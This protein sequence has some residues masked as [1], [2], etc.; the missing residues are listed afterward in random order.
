M[1]GRTARQKTEEWIRRYHMADRGDGVLAA[2]SGGADSVCLLLLLCELRETLGIRV[3]AFHLNHG[4]RGAEADWDE[5]YVRALCEKLG[6][7]LTVR[8]EDVASYAVSRRL[9]EEEA[10]RRLRYQYLEETAD[11][12]GFRRIAT[13]HHRDDCAETVLMNL[14]RG[15]GLSGLSGIPPVRGRVIRPLL[16]LS[17]EEI[18]A[19]LTERGIS[20]CEDSTN[21]ENLHT[22]NRIRN[23]LLP[24]VKES[25]NPRAAEHIVRTAEVAAQAEA[26]FEALAVK[27][28]D[29][30]QAGRDAAKPHE[31]EPEQETPDAPSASVSLAC[32]DAQPEIVRYYLIRELLYQAGCGRKDITERHIRAILG[33]SG[34]GAGTRV[35]LPG[36]F[37]AVRGY[38]ALSV[39]RRQ[40]EADPGELCWE[41]RVFPREKDGEIP[42]N[43]YTKW[44]D[45]DKIKGTLILRTR[46]EG[47]YFTLAGGGKK[48]LRRYFIDEKIPE[49]SRDK[50]PL[51][52]DGSHILW[53]V[54]GRIS[55]A[56]KVDAATGTI[57]EIRILPPYPV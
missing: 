26:Y 34:P 22:R 42:R 47:D 53:I 28:L 5:A 17:R 41:S 46:R 2:V 52:A 3:A 1:D 36:D 54:G 8:R 57:L 49:S 15:S 33:L 18:E 20:W 23:E 56:Y 37:I 31:P 10:G 35:D 12:L 43:R 50:I 27:L 38:D 40:T 13:A 6:V 44:F 21:H 14:F 30:D 32:M 24:R 55:E 7:A 11:G 29:M 45:Y 9:T 39:R 19:Y 25:V 4:L 16:A 48:M 51:F